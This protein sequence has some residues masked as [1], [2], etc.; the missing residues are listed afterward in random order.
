MS[1]LELAK[2][3]RQFAQK[4]VSKRSLYPFG[5][6][7]GGGG[8][9]RAMLESA[10]RMRDLAGV[11]RVETDT[12]ASFWEKVRTEAA[13]LPVWVGEL[14]LEYHRGTYTTNGPIKRANR[15]NEQALRAAELWSV[16]VAELNNDWSAYPA[17]CSTRRGSCFSSTSSTTS[18]PVPAFTG[19]TR[20]PCAITRRSR[21]RP[22]R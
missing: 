16:A 12:V 15:K 4:A 13:E 7:D 21:P 14:Y 18:F 1:V 11:P 5:Y 20:T 17:T 3:D 6:G 19:P 8:P 10:R 22:T 2:G 9:T